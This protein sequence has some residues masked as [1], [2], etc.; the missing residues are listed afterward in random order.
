MKRLNL[1][2]VDRLTEAQKAAIADNPRVEGFIR[3]FGHR[4]DM[5]NR[6]NAF[7]ERYCM[8]DGLLPARLKEI[9]RLRVAQRNGCHL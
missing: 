5:L 6:F 7:Y 9:V 8:V 1:L 2:P 4:Q 3:S